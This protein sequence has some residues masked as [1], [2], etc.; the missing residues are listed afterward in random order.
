MTVI[1]ITGATP[2]NRARRPR[3]ELAQQG[4]EVVIVG[5]EPDRVAAVAT[6]PGRPARRAGSTPTWPTCR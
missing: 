3:S 1:V 5:R 4:A 2:R 6:E